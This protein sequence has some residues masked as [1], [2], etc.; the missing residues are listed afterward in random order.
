MHAEDTASSELGWH[1]EA[2]FN[3]VIR[4]VTSSSRLSLFEST[5]SG[6]LLAASEPRGFPLQELSDAGENAILNEG[7]GLQV[8]PQAYFRTSSIDAACPEINI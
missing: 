7:P 1:K 8:F 6:H 2:I 5:L 3:A 4:D